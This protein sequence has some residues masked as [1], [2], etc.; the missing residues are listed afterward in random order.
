MCSRDG[1]QVILRVPVWV[2]NNYDTCSGQ[3]NSEATS[4]RGEEKDTE[5][6]IVIKACYT[7]TSIWALD[8]TGEQLEANTF[9]LEVSLND[10][11]HPLE[12]REH[13]H[14]VAFLLV[15][16]DE[17]VEKDQFPRGFEHLCQEF[18]VCFAISDQF[19]FNTFQEVEMIA[20]LPQLDVDI[21]ELRSFHRARA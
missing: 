1:L 11:N 13:Q 17:L 10:V 8:A 3:I 18:S 9:D 7:Y 19:L 4:S 15:L 14:F 21:G 6:M 2:K 5:F 20:T 12:L 16:F